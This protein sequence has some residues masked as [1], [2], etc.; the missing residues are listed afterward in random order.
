MATQSIVNIKGLCDVLGSTI[1]TLRKN[2]RGLPHF[3]VDTG[4]DLRSARFDVMD[5][6]N[7]LKSSGGNYKCL[8]K[9]TDGALG[10]KILFGQNTIQERRLPMPSRR[11]PMGS[12]KTTRAQGAHDSDPYSLLPGGCDGIS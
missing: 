10:R 1:N 11:T 4:T 6:I 2:W 7:H 5:V 9:Q 12:P 3:Y 8:E